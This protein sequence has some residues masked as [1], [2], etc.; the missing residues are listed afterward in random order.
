MQVLRPTGLADALEARAAR[1]DA[2]ALRGGTDVMVAIN[3]RRVR[4]PALLD[5]GRVAE[6]GDWSPENGRLRIGA[7]MTH[8]RLA[9]ELDEHAPA[10]ARAA[11]ATGSLQV[12]NRGTLGG[13]VGTASPSGDAL[14]ALV[15]AGADAELAGPGGTRRVPVEALVTGPHATALRADE[16]IAAFHVPRAAGPEVYAKVGA[17]NAMV[18]GTVSLA[19]GLDPGRRTVRAAAGSAGPTPLRMREAEEHAAGALDWDGLAPADAEAV[20][21]FAALV[22][23][24]A[25]PVDDVRGTAAYRRHA[26]GVLARRCL[27]WA[28]DAHR[29]A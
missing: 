11:L 16:L 7:G 3:F 1:P 12:R 2:L 5:L 21:R 6:L 14:C 18:M 10:L 23:G 4:P 27:T 24:A 26:L 25:R 19:L 8:A 22:T 28:W 9:A 17:R 20:A 29:A 15:G 13:N